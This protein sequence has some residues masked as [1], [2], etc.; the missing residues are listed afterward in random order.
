M[1]GREGEVDS[2]EGAAAST[3]PTVSI[4]T[5]VLNGARYLE[6]S[7]DSVLGQSRP[8]DE[9]IVID[10]GSTDGSVEIIR[11]REHRLAYWCSEPDRGIYDAMNKGIRRATGDIVGILNSD[12]WYEEDSLEAVTRGYQ[13]SGAEIV[14][15]AIAVHDEDGT[16]VHVAQPRNYPLARLFSTPFKHPAMFVARTAYDRIGLYDTEFRLAA[17]YDWMLRAVR[18]GVRDLRLK[19]CLTHVGLTGVTTSTPGI[20]APDELVRL[21]QRHTGSTAAARAILGLRRVRRRVGRWRR[22]R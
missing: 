18:S 13:R 6:R 8:P 11:G 12:D 21:L 15:G 14:H 5:V 9:Y 22:R 1:T 20:S 16:P 2:T 19:R 3:S 17:D 4:V 10:G 7:M